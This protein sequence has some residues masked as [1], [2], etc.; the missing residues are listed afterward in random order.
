VTLIAP[1]GPQYLT[2]CPAE[3]PKP[4]DAGFIT[5]CEAASVVASAPVPTDNSLLISC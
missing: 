4:D 3:N 5:E 2:F 1:L